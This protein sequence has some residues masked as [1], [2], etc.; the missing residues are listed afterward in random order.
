VHLHL[1]ACNI[2]QRE[3]CACLARTPHVVDVEFIQLGEHARPDNLRALLQARIDAAAASGQPCDAV[4]LL[5]GLCGNAGVGLAARAAPLVVPRAH[6]CATILLGSRAAFRRHFGD[7]PSQGFS[8]NGYLDRGD[9]FLRTAEEGG[10]AVCGGDA[11]AELVKQHGEENARYVWETMHP[12]RPGSDR[13]IFIRLPGIDDAD[14]AA[15]FRGR[16]AAEGKTAEE[17]TGDLRLIEALIAGRW[18]PAEFLV[19]PPGRVT[20][21]VYDWEEIVR[22]RPAPPADRDSLPPAGN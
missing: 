17:L 13:A 1:I 18:D 15:R 10:G 12:Q 16:A 4:L 5:F 21:G 22:C 19:V 6:D 14:H 3:A 8:S 7:N 2:F 9:Y 20:A 11:Y